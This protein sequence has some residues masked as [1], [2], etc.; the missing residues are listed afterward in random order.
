MHAHIHRHIFRQV[1]FILD[2]EVPLDADVV[3]L[4]QQCVE[5]IFLAKVQLQLQGARRKPVLRHVAPKPHEVPRIGCKVHVDFGC[6]I[7]DA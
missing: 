5:R 2:V 7:L 1:H 4:A 6:V 3:A